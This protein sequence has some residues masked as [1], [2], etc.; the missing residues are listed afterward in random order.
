MERQLYIVTAKNLIFEG[1][2]VES[3]PMKLGRAKQTQRKWKKQY[4]RKV[5]W[6]IVKYEPIKEVQ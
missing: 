1:D 3:H 4:A 5:D 2:I 6:K